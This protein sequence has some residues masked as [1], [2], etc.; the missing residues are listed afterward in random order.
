MPVADFLLRSRS[1]SAPGSSLLI[2]CPMQSGHPR[3]Y[4][5]TDKNRVGRLFW[6]ILYMFM[7]VCIYVY[8]CNTCILSSREEKVESLRVSRGHGRSWREG[9]LE[10]VEGEKRGRKWCNYI[11]TKM[12]K[13]CILGGKSRNSTQ[14]LV[15]LPA[16]SFPNFSFPGIEF[17]CLLSL[18][19]EPEHLSHVNMG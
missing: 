10:W 15:T 4:I 12:Y 19:A 18:W 1:S 13:I 9:T 2:D 6:Y 5:H 14:T 17:L 7:F 16:C 11:L 8:V 3:N